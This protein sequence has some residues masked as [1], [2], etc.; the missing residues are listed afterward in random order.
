VPRARAVSGRNKKSAEP[1]LLRRCTQRPSSLRAL[2]RRKRFEDLP[3]EVLCLPVGVDAALYRQK[4][5]QPFEAI[6]RDP[7]DAVFGR[8][9]R[10]CRGGQPIVDLPGPQWRRVRIR[11]ICETVLP[12]RRNRPE[13]R[14]RYPLIVRLGRPKCNLSSILFGRSRATDTS[15]QW[16]SWRACSDR[17]FSGCS[18]GDQPG[19]ICCARAGCL[20]RRLSPKARV[21]SAA[22]LGE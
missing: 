11:K 6:C 4:P 15:P 9:R 8:T 10:L 3:V 16:A 22:P 19:D 20:S 2:I 21:L 7:E 14:G 13:T 1:I 17:G 5:D 12:R 18:L